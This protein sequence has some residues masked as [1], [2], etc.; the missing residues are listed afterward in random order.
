MLKSLVHIQ[1]IRR[2]IF[3]PVAEQRYQELVVV[4]FVMLTQQRSKRL[5]ARLDRLQHMLPPSSS[6]INELPEARLGW[7]TQDIRGQQQIIGCCD[8]EFTLSTAIREI[9]VR[10]P[11][12]AEIR[13]AILRRASPARTCQLVRAPNSQGFK[14]CGLK[15]STCLCS[16]FPRFQ[17]LYL[18]ISSPSCII[19]E[20]CAAGSRNENQ[21]LLT[22]ND[23]DDMTANAGTPNEATPL[24][25][26]TQQPERPS[27][28][29][30]LH[31]TSPRNIVL[32]LAL[33][34]LILASAGGL[35]VVPQT[36]LLEDIFCHLHYGDIKGL[37]DIDESLCKID[38]IQS[39]LAYVNGL[40]TAVEAVV[41]MLSFPRSCPW[42]IKYPRIDF[43]VSLWN[44]R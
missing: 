23:D 11:Q 36:R 16:N 19:L 24:L 27:A 31:V 40:I 15:V 33:N 43:R 17:Q 22:I 4:S 21:G 7:K 13:L 20:R 26:E 38:S 9:G 18:R 10:S 32:L 5:L 37:S 6:R 34:I 30:R 14:S 28:T 29:S 35:T 41:G 25:S 39:E 42:L 3:Q 8:E 44:P 2:Y 1:S 12:N